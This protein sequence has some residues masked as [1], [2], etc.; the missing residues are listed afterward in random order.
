MN[1]YI[2]AIGNAVPAFQINQ[3]KGAEWMAEAL[4][5]P[6]KEKRIIHALYAATGIESRYTVIEDFIK[7]RGDYRFFPNSSSMEPFPKTEKRMDF[8]K[9]E[10]VPL[11][12][13]AISD[14]L[15]GRPDIKTSDYTHIIFA[16]C[17]GMY[18][19]GPETEIIRYLG[20]NKNLERTSILFLG[21]YAAFNAIKT[22]DYICR[23]D[24]D[25]Q[26]LVICA[27]LC[28][29][30][31]QKNRTHDILVSN[32]LFGDGAAA[33]TISGKKMSGLNLNLSSFHCLLT[34]D[35]GKNM[36]W[37]I[38]DTGFQMTL[39]GDIPILVQKGLHDLSEMNSRLKSM[40]FFDYYAIHPG[41]KKILE[42][43]ENELKLTKD[44]T[45][46][47]FNILKKYGNMSSPT[48]LFVL[49]DISKKLSN[50]DAGKNILGLAF[51]PG[52]T[53]ES[54]TL[55]IIFA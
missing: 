51:G 47:S 10:I 16:S 39:S 4:Q 34:D 15:S 26:V 55:E 36:A 12:L 41:G 27:E 21:C 31:F 48:I 18:A 6:E 14:M 54:M 49:K 33:V 17:T 38:C 2:N 30:H 19:P 25:S 28:T 5:S 50:N 13:S 52:L 29:L 24:P 43:C 44:D 20:L 32:A 11:S 7:K 40:N 22:A 45:S 46:Y 8:Y 23:A 35:F 53:V 37:E 3:A 42:A 9:K 1:S